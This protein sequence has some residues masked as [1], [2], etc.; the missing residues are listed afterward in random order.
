MSPRTSTIFLLVLGVTACGGLGNPGSGDDSTN[1]FT[2]TA[3]PPW[4]GSETGAP[5]T[6]GGTQGQDSATV[7]G[8][9][10]SMSGSSS[11]PPGGPVTTGDGGG[12]GSTGGSTSTSTGTSSG[13]PPPGPKLDLPPVFSTGNDEDKDK[14][15]DES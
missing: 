6:S 4:M 10:E 5:T 1:P 8:G 2:T 3:V 12:T 14:D 11:G 13:D 15:K 9:T 7:S